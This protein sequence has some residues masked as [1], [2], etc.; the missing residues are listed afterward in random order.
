MQLSVV[1]LEYDQGPETVP[2]L[3]ARTLDG[4]HSL[5]HD[6]LVGEEGE[7]SVVAAARGGTVPEHLV[8]SGDYT[9]RWKVFVEKPG[10]MRVDAS[11]SA[12]GEGPHGTLSVTA[13]SSTL[14][15]ALQPTGQNTY[16]LV[17]VKNDVDDLYLAFRYDDPIWDCEVDA[18]KNP[19]VIDLFTLAFDEDGSLT[20]DT[21]EDQNVVMPIWSGGFFDKYGGGSNDVDYRFDGF[22]RMRYH[23]SESR[24]HVEFRIPLDSTDADD[25]SIGSGDTINFYVGIV[26]GLVYLGTAIQSLAAGYMTPVGEAAKDPKNWLGW[27][28]FLV[29]FGVIGFVLA[30]RIWHAL[31]RS[32]SQPPRR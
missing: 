20:L 19:T 3:A 22:G 16:A 17:L 30:C 15:H 5:R 23:A 14:E 29:P 28:V 12:Q 10:R 4:G 21:G 27:P 7:R 32:R 9:C 25:I 8:V 13:G 11:Y 31:P 24:F 6:N 26:D 1:A 18:N 2:G